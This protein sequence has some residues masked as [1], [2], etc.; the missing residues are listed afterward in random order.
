[1]SGVNVVERDVVVIGDGVIGLS[2]A[3]TLAD[4]GVSSV[5]LGSR[6]RGAATLASAGLLAPSIGRITTDVRA[7][8][9]KARDAYPDFLSR[10][11][12]RCDLPVE[13]NRSGLIELA[14]DAQGFVDLCRH[15]P[16]WAQVIPQ[17]E[18]A[19]L[20]PALASSPGALLHP[21]DGFV[22]NVALLAA[23]DRAVVHEQLIGRVLAVAERVDVSTSEVRSSD[24]VSYRGRTIVLAAGAWSGLLAGLPT[25]LPVEPL[26]GE[27]LAVAADSARPLRHAVTGAQGYLVPR[28]ERVLVGSTEERLGFSVR[29]SEENAG[30]LRK[31]L[32]ALCPPLGDS[33]EQAHWAGLRPVTPD[34]RPII[35]RDPR[36]EHLLY[37]CGHSR[38][39]ILLAPLTATV[40]AD[41]I[42]AGSTSVEIAPFAITRFANRNEQSRR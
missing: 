33:P 10:L 8:Y 15:A 7:T 9:F 17:D 16:S 25:P 35:G 12:A 11:A 24:G 28:G 34:R 13:L 29:T 1:M 6:L 22:D 40:T 32:R 19:K 18:L 38:N 31:A 5:V 3:I 42:V 26:H 36:A 14:R 21:D 30:S 37:A 39:G 23:L 20:E 2:I 41:L 27:M 4:R